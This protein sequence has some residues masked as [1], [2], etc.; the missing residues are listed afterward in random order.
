MGLTATTPHWASVGP[1]TGPQSWAFFVVTH[2]AGCHRS[3]AVVSSVGGTSPEE[4]LQGYPLVA[5]CERIVNIFADRANHTA[6]R[7]ELVLAVEYY[8]RGDRV[9]CPESVELPDPSRIRSP[10]SVRSQSWDQTGVA[11]FPFI[12]TC[13]LQGVG[14]DAEN[15][16]TQLVRLEPLSTV[17]RD[18][19]TKWG[20]VVVDIT[21]LD[22]VNY[23]IVGFTASGAGFAP[24][25]EAESHALSMGTAGQD[26]MCLGEIRV[27]EELRPRRAMSAAEYMDKFKYEPFTNGYAIQRL[28]QTAIVDISA[29][30]SV[31]SQGVDA[32]EIVPLLASLAMASARS[33]QDQVITSLIEITLD[34]DDFDTSIFDKLY[35]IPNFK[36]L[37][38]HSLMQHSARLDNTRSVGKLLRLAF[39]EQKHLA[40]ECLKNLS[41]TAVLAALEVP[42]MDRMTGI[43]LCIDNIKSTAAQLAD[44]ISRAAPLNELYLFQSPTRHDDELSVKLFEELSSR[45]QILSGASV[46]VA[47]AY[48]AALRRKL[49]LTTSPRPDVA[50]QPAPVVTSPIRPFITSCSTCLHLQT[51]SGE[52]Q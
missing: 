50:V 39:A 21:N 8:I 40:L 11:E 4:S 35:E 7:G 41:A 33:L 30:K 28:T 6:I 10:K 52:I 29:L 12:A 14:F 9:Y 17:Y 36:D 24:S 27:T 15:K 32:D 26:A 16:V 45:P 42:G 22:M 44:V 47:G 2:V 38:R 37:L 5:A 20:M 51:S 13:L 25:A 1:Y 19:N 49:W 43:S 3:V 34:H 46:M 18:A 23:G 31:W 48:S